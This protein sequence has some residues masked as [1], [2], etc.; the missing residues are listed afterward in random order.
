MPSSESSTGGIDVGTG[1][2]SGGGYGIAMTLQRVTSMSIASSQC[3]T[4]LER[5]GQAGQT[6]VHMALRPGQTA[7]SK[8]EMQQLDK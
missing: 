3:G 1:R 8:H 2:G 5:P 4:C 6:R 7:Q